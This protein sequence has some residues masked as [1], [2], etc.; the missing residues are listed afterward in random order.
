MPGS[1]P[2]SATEARLPATRSPAAQPDGSA[3]RKELAAF[4]R[5]FRANR[6]GMA[7]AIPL[8]IIIAIALLAPIIA[9]YAPDD[10]HTNWKLYPPN[11]YFLLGTDE[12]GRDLLSRI[13]YG[14][15]IS[16]EV[17]V[18][19]V[20]L[21][22]SVGTFIGLIAGFYGGWLDN[23]LMRIMDVLFAFPA[24]LLAIGIMAM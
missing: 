18:F 13:M 2:A 12:L 3:T 6:V 21:A 17:G 15:Q 1:T 20:A 11:E 19:S 8:A 24:I 22:L 16:L 4:W 14:A 10:I 5:R 9:P 7:G 23:V